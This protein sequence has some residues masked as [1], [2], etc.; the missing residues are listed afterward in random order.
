M[1]FSSFSRAI[2]VHER[3]LSEKQLKHGRLI[4]TFHPPRGD[5]TACYFE[6]VDQ[7]EIYYNNNKYNM[8]MHFSTD[9]LFRFM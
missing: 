3:L 9:K 1:I 5:T 6:T 4:S 2:S 8:A 7:Q